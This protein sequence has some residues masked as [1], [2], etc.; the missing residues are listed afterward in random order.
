VTNFILNKLID[1]P[2]NYNHLY[3]MS[4]HL[5]QFKKFPNNIFQNFAQ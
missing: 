3:I 1:R 2:T 4:F 5:T